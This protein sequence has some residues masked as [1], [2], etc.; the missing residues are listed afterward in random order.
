VSPEKLDPQD[1]YPGA[2]NYDVERLEGLLLA[3]RESG[4]PVD[5]EFYV[6]LDRAEI[7]VFGITSKN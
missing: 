6:R 5:Q 7:D 3:R 2:A 4:D 1:D